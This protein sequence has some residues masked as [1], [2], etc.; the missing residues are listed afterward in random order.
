MNNKNVIPT[1]R[2]YLVRNGWDEINSNLYIIDQLNLSI[3]F[4]SEGQFDFYV[5]NEIDK[6]PP[7]DIYMH[8]LS[9]FSDIET[10]NKTLR[11][12]Q[13]IKDRGFT[14]V[15]DSGSFEWKDDNN[16]IIEEN[17][18]GYIIQ[19]FEK[20]YNYASTGINL[21]RIFKKNDIDIALIS[22]GYLEVCYFST[23]GFLGGD[24]MFS[25]DDI[26]ESILFELALLLNPLFYHDKNKHCLNLSPATKNEIYKLNKDYFDNY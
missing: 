11:L 20:Y 23:D 19:S 6:Y 25:G 4:S 8:S 14:V 13:I 1:I 9:V 24:G 5:N 3:K 18:N 16:K 21:F 10:Y 22:K 7:L 2:E 12:I 17:I 15:Y 26:L